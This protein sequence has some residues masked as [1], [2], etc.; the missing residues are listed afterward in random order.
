MDTFPYNWQTLEQGAPALNGGPDVEPF[1]AWKRLRSDSLGTNELLVELPADSSN[2]VETFLVFGRRPPPVYPLSGRRFWTL[3]GAARTAPPAG[4]AWPPAWLHRVKAIGGDDVLFRAPPAPDPAVTVPIPI[5]A[6]PVDLSQPVTKPDRPAVA[7]VIA[8]IDTTIA[9]LHDQFRRP[10]E[11]AHTRIVA[12]WDQDHDERTRAL[13][14][15][16]EVKG[17]EYGREL[18]GDDIEDLIQQGGS[19]QAMYKAQ[20]PTQ[21]PPAWSHGTQVLA[22]AAGVQDPMVPA[23]PPDAAA[24]LDIIAVQLPRRAVAQTHG[25]WLNTY[26]LDGIHYALDRAPPKAPV[27]V[28]ISMGGSLGPH[29]GTSL[30]E[31]AIND[32]VDAS[33]GR[34]TVVLAA[35]N[36]R[37]SGMHICPHPASSQAVTFSVSTFSDDRTPNFV[38]M[39]STGNEGSTL[40]LQVAVAN[41][42][43]PLAAPLELDPGHAAALYRAS[44]GLEPPVAIACLSRPG[45][46]ANGDGSQAF[47]GIAAVKDVSA[48]PP[49]PTGEWTFTLASSKPAQVDVWLGR[50]DIPAGEDAPAQ[51]QLQFDDGPQPLQAGTLSSVAG[52]SQ[53][54]SIVVGAYRALAGHAPEMYEPSGEGGGRFGGPDVCGITA[55]GDGPGAPDVWFCSDAP[56]PDGVER[57]AQQGTSMAAPFVARRIANLLAQRKGAWLKKSEVL[58]ALRPAQHVVPQPPGQSAWTAPFWL[59]P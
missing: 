38:D 30:L 27:I 32:L 1:S 35:G 50:D 8:V 16:R 2:E 7:P 45:R 33:D 21:V 28:N 18:R 9:Y 6:R 11:P 46:A 37:D 48:G 51:P 49:A 29:D 40:K 42:A 13:A 56:P 43:G 3:R 22:I 53:S 39:W 12:L 55:I 54:R 23:G 41:G 34:L 17:F 10:G 25:V 20:T 59:G 14:P 44:G 26:V 24:G 52:G 19:Q 5:P 47:V 31:Q 57:N 4:V 15:W 58:A 36:A